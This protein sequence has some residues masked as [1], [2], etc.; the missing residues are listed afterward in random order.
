MLGQRNLSH[1]EAMPGDACFFFSVFKSWNTKENGAAN[2]SFFF[3]WIET[4]S[5]VPVSQWNSVFQARCP[6]VPL[7]FMRACAQ[8]QQPCAVSATSNDVAENAH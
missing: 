4:K 2:I 3:F 5:R 1:G 7:R 6:T 8:S